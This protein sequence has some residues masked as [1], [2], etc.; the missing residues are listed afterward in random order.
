MRGAD[1]AAGEEHVVDEHHDPAGDVDGDL[2][3]AE[4]ACTARRPMSS[5]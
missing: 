2:G 1:G 4:R 3:G 5:R